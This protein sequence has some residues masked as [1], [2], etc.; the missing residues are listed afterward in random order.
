MANDAV[1]SIELGSTVVLAGAVSGARLQA[2]KSNA[3]RIGV[4]MAFPR[5]NSST[6]VSLADVKA[7]DEPAIAGQ[8]RLWPKR[9]WSV[10]QRRRANL[11]PMRLDSA[12]LMIR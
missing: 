1:E 5:D 12:A 9:Q 11:P 6:D 4:R 8:V 10:R 7:Y 3:K 2:A